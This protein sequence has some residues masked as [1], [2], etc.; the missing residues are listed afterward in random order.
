MSRE[1][2][3][4]AATLKALVQADEIPGQVN[5][6]YATDANNTIVRPAFNLDA[7]NPAG[8][9]DMIWDNGGND[10]VR[11]GAG[12]DWMI[13]GRGRDSYNGQSGFDVVAYVRAD[14]AVRADLADTNANSAF[15]ETNSQ[16]FA[17]GDRF[18]D[19]EGL[20]GSRFGDTLRGHFENGSYLNGYDGNDTLT[21]GRGADVIKGGK[22][23]DTV[24]AI[25][26][27]GD[28]LFGG[29]G[30]DTITAGRNSVISGGANSDRFIFD[31]SL[32]VRPEND[33]PGAINGTPNA[34]GEIVITDWN[35]GGAQDR[36][37]FLGLEDEFSMHIEQDGADRVITFDGVD[38]E[39]RLLD[40]T[41]QE[42]LRSI[43]IG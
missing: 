19:V 35:V 6:V 31:I 30:N 17:F 11:A 7:S 26:G 9:N 29:S 21:G 25:Q 13:A 24:N 42:M 22:D 37:R 39:I 43:S 41:V 18:Q 8:M 12:D 38:G 28:E 27:N 1:A 16:S 40:T 36:I 4:R 20:V 10:I 33:D 34:M 14:T 5:F 3:D 23:N 15:R 32:Y 2:L